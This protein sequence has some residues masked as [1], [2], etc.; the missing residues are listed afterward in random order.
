MYLS[1]GWNA[2]TKQCAL[3]ANS[4]L[5]PLPS[6]FPVG[7]CEFEITTRGNRQV[8]DCLSFSSAI[9]F[10]LINL[11]KREM[12][13]S[14]PKVHHVNDFLKKYYPCR[15]LKSPLLLYIILYQITCWVRISGKMF[16]SE[17]VV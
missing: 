2:F 4:G 11:A 5:L 17:E 15:F 7:K 13:L 12:L 9:T 8:S 14:L 10:V 1:I 16:A 3:S 6:N